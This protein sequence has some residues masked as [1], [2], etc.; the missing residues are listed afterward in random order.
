M[1]LPVYRGILLFL[2]M[3]KKWIGLPD[4]VWRSKGRP[5]AGLPLNPRSIVI[6][7]CKEVREIFLKPEEV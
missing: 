6:I 7:A 5:N 3:N 1:V 2:D 4:T